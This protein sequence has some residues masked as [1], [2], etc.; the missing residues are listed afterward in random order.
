M[1]ICFKDNQNVG[2]LLTRRRLTTTLAH[3]A[4]DPM[5]CRGRGTAH[6]VVWVKAKRKTPKGWR[7][8]HFEGVTF[9]LFSVISSVWPSDIKLY[10]LLI[11]VVSVLFFFSCHKDLL[12]TALKLR[13]NLL[14]TSQ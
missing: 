14:Y 10:V 5:D 8:V 3:F 2:N 13:V 1:I 12:F 6:G 7:E 11:I 9:P 4:H